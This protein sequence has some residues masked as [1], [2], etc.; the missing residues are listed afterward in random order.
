MHT[1][2]THCLNTLVYSWWRGQYEVVLTTS[3]AYSAS[4]PLSLTSCRSA[5]FG[6]GPPPCPRTKPQRQPHTQARHRRRPYARRSADWGQEE[7][8]RPPAISHMHTLNTHCL[9]TLVYSWWRGQDEL[10]VTVSHVN[11]ASGSHSLT[12][13]CRS[14]LFGSGHAA[15]PAHQADTHAAPTHTSYVEEKYTDR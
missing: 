7:R 12:V 4:A 14:A 1:F 13:V 3:H 8:Q 5:L 6:P 2:T 15:M 9:N 10:V 11:S